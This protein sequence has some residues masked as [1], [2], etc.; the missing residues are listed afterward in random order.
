MGVGH[1]QYGNLYLQLL[2]FEQR[3]E[4]QA[5]WT[6]KIRLT[7]YHRRAY[8]T[9]FPGTR[10]RQ[11]RLLKKKKKRYQNSLAQSSIPIYSLTIP[12][13]LAIGFELQFENIWLYSPLL[14]TWWRSAAAV[15]L[16]R[17]LRI[18]WCSYRTP[19]G[20][21]QLLVLCNIST[22]INALLVK[23]NSYPKTS[24]RKIR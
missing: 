1:L 19:K 8:P 15:F 2:A 13:F 21:H 16:K 22:N 10:V 18:W 20:I 4:G 7:T 14:N 24:V 23:Q 12:H 6:R 3:S 9:Q 11:S 5:Q 17:M